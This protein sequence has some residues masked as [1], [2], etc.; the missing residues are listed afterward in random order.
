MPASSTVAA[1]PSSFRSTSGCSMQACSRRNGNRLTATNYGMTQVTIV[2]HHRGGGASGLQRTSR[3]CRRAELAL[4]APDGTIEAANT[5]GSHRRIVARQN[6]GLRDGTGGIWSPDGRRVAYVTY[7]GQ[8]LL[9]HDLRSWGTRPGLI[10]FRLELQ[11]WRTRATPATETG[12]TSTAGPSAW[13]RGT[14]RCG[15]C[16][17]TGGARSVSARRGSGL[18]WRHG[19]SPCTRWKSHRV[20]H[21]P[22]HRRQSPGHSRPLDRHHVGHSRRNRLPA[23]LVT[24]R[25]QHCLPEW[26]PEPRS[27]RHRRVGWNSPRAGSKVGRP[28][29]TGRSA[30]L[31][32]LNGFLPPPT[33]SRW[34]LS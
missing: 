13:Y 12:S 10:D 22:R 25:G 7:S 30:G 3:S 28:S 24:A 18:R 20:G 33:C 21:D 29:T 9:Q 27:V 16:I 14:G 6:A 1:T 8:L 2:R 19:P 32:T 23:Q 15:G 4:I 26:L 5:D 17:R 34:P 11:P 31:P